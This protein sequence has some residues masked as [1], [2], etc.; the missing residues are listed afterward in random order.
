MVSIALTC[1]SSPIPKFAAQIIAIAEILRAHAFARP[2]VLIDA[3]PALVVFDASGVSIGEKETRLSEFRSSAQIQPRMRLCRY[4]LCLRTLED[5]RFS[6][7]HKMQP[8]ERRTEVWRQSTAQSARHQKWLNKAIQL[9][10]FRKINIVRSISHFVK[11]P[12]LLRK[13]IGQSRFATIQT[14][15]MRSRDALTRRVGSTTVIHFIH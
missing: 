4:Q 13:L 6:L 2:R 5:P 15:D 10:P 3:S 7:P 9:I 1:I 8:P 12:P 11:W 14:Y